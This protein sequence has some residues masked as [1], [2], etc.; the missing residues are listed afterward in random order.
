MLLFFCL[1]PLAWVQLE[2]GAVPGEGVQTWGPLAVI[3]VILFAAAMIRIAQVRLA[4]PLAAPLAPT[5]ASTRMMEN[6]TSR[7]IAHPVQIHPTV[8]VLGEDVVHL[9]VFPLIQDA[10][11]VILQVLAHKDV[12]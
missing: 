7:R 9:R 1:H 11:I 8:V 10:Q 12:R 6:A 2:R 3:I 4:A 5:A